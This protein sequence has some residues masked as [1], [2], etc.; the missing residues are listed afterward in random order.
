MGVITWEQ[1]KDQFLDFFGELTKRRQTD[2]VAKYQTSFEKLL[3]KAG[4]MLQN[5]QL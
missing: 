2:T 3:A 5:K 1:F 4:P